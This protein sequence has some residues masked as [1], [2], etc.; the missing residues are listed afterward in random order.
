[1]LF[2]LQTHMGLRNC[3]LD[4]GSGPH[5]KEIGIFERDDCGVFLHGA[6]QCF[7]WLATVSAFAHQMATRGA[8]AFSQIILDKLYYYYYY[9]LAHQ[10]KAANTKIRN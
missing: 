6:E 1:M 2:G 3:V 5:G 4:G 7:E 8:V 9:F 10:H